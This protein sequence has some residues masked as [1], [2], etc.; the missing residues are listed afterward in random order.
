VWSS[1]PEAQ[2]WVLEPLLDAGLAM[3]QIRPL[4]FQLAFD[5]LVSD[6]NATV[7]GLHAIVR[8]Q[9]AGVQAAWAEMIGRMLA[10]SGASD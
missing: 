3:D 7:A 4:V 1:A 8:D 9:P 2:H 5:D 6:G 10:V